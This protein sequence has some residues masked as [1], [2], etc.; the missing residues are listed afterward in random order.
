MPK[1]YQQDNKIANKRDLSVQLKKTFYAAE[2]IRN[3]LWGRPKNISQTYY[4]NEEALELASAFVK[5]YVKMKEVGMETSN[6]II[7]TYFNNGKI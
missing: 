3:K 4:D 1:Y 5:N 6:P 7:K 2:P